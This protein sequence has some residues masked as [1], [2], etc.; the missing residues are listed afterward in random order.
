VRF[1]DKRR[2]HQHWEA[3][4]FYKDGERLNFAER[5][6]KSPQVRATRGSVYSDGHVKGE[7]LRPSRASVQSVHASREEARRRVDTR[8][9]IVPSHCPPNS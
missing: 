9:R 8:R 5:Q 6:K 2:K 7:A 4:I 3:T 1:K